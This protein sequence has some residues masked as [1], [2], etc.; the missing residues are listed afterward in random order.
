[1]HIRYSP[2][3]NAGALYDEGLEGRPHQAPHEP[4]D[5]AKHQTA[6]R[7]VGELIAKVE[8]SFPGRMALRIDAAD[9]RDARDLVDLGGGPTLEH[10]R[11]AQPM[12]KRPGLA[13]NVR[14]GAPEA[15]LQPHLLLPRDA[16]RSS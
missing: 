10:G 15:G 12:E 3:I 2:S 13:G 8:T 16:P 7:A 1:M 5:G 4:V 14:D 11:F 6:T 9:A